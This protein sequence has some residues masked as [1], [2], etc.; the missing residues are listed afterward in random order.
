VWGRPRTD[1]HVRA[2]GVALT[3]APMDLPDT[4]ARLARRAPAGAAPWVQRLARLGYAAKGVVYALVGG[5]ALAAA[6]G[7][8]GRAEG[9]D[10]ALATVV[11]APF[12]RALLGVIA[13]GLVGHVVWRL[14][15]A[16]LDPEG[17]GSDSKGLAQ[18]AGLALSAAI[19]GV[20]ALE[21]VRLARGTGG[22][23][24]GD[25]AS[26]WTARALDLPF[27]RVLVGLVGVGVAAYGVY[28]GVKAVRSDV[29][30]RLDLSGLGA[31]GRTNV[32]RAGRAGLAARGVVFVLVGGFLLS[33]AWQEQAAEARGLDGVLRTL[34]RQPYGP[35][36]LGLVA[37]GLA[38]YGVFQLVQARYR[39]IRAA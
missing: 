35:V 21:A 13:F 16:G 39:R 33:A 36:V 38:A 5:L 18:R 4:A 20:L 26:H 12:G 34:E 28:Q 11:S 15:Q 31:Q 19:Y 1:R 29:C 8:R 7:E 2:Y 3:T 37:L 17:R 25:A 10:G 30:K 24:G 22:G 23:G 27:G 32:E 9:A 14:V 6:F